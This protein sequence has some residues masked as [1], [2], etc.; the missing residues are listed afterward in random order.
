M[1]AGRRNAQSVEIVILEGLFAPGTAGTVKRFVAIITV[2]WQIAVL[3]VNL[4]FV[5]KLCKQINVNQ[6]I[7]L[8]LVSISAVRSVSGLLISKVKR[9]PFFT[10]NALTVLKT[11]STTIIQ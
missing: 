9:L 11:K 8:Y 3:E 10:M 1:T 7:N 4:A 5:N 2:V 6:I